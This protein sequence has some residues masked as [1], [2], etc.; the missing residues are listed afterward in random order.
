MLNLTGFLNILQSEARGSAQGPNHASSQEGRKS[1]TAQYHCNHCIPPS[2]L[3]SSASAEATLLTAT[4]PR[5][6]SFSPVPGLRCPTNELTTTP[7]GI[8]VIHVGCFRLHIGDTYLIGAT[9]HL[10]KVGC[11][12]DI[13]QVL[14]Q[15][16]STTRKAFEKLKASTITF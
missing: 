15:I 9:A 6:M 7:S 2:T 8:Q 10:P 4:K 3:P 1:T 13:T 16:S 5:H 11:S 14:A 12:R